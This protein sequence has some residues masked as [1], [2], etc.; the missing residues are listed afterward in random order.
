MVLLIEL[1]VLLMTPALIYHG[2]I[3]KNLEFVKV[4][5][6]SG[7][8]MGLLRELAVVSIGSLYGYGDFTLTILGFPIIYAVLWSNL[9]YIGWV[10]S[11]NYIGV[12]FLKS[13]PWDQ[14][15]P[16][17]FATSLMFAFFFETLLSQYHMIHWQI[18]SIMTLWG[19]MPVL[20]PFAYGLTSVLFMKSVKWV[21]LKPQQS[22][23]MITL[24]LLAVQ[25]FV[26]LVLMGILLIIDLLIILVFS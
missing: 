19:G 25:P 24:K 6:I 17:M 4:F 18:D 2:I 9:S 26:I 16:L 13:K 7:L 10:W 14:H 22:W 5:W 8:F 1:V 12:D 15:L 23:Q 3:T 21:S 20:A 11:N